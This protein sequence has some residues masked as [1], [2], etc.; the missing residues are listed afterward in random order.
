MLS[1]YLYTRMCL[2]RLCV[3]V[4]VCVCVWPKEDIDMKATGEQVLSNHKRKHEVSPV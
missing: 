3:C 1:M 2:C 4:C